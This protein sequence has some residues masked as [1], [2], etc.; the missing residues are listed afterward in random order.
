MKRTEKQAVVEALVDRLSRSNSIY[1][2]DFTGLSVKNMTEL[3]RRLRSARVDYVV[4]K[5]TLALRALKE[6]SVTGLD[7]TITG[8]TGFVLVEDDP[9]GAAKVLGGFRKEFKGKPSF[10]A[11]VVSGRPVTPDEINRL[12]VLP[13]RDVLI[14]ELGRALQAPFR[15]FLGTMTALLYQFVRSLE[16]LRA[17]RETLPNP[18]AERDR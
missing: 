15:G 7:D 17:Q 12:A 1:L 14:G 10:K 8:P 2:T 18:V 5:N 9:A 11:G 3:R 6:A 13:G 4:V 16:A